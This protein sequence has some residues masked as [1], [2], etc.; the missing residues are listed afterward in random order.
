M[1]CGCVN[2][3]SL[4]LQPSAT[5]FSGTW[6]KLAVL[7]LVAKSALHASP[8]C[9]VW[10]HDIN[11]QPATWKSKPEAVWM[12]KDSVF[13]K[14]PVWAESWRM[15]G[16]ICRQTAAQFT[17]VPIS[18]QSLVASSFFPSASSYSVVHRVQIIISAD[19]PASLLKWCRF[20]NGAV[21]CNHSLPHKV[22]PWWRF[23]ELHHL[24]LGYSINT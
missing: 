16:L 4:H 18:Q 17:K 6:G 1:G 10:F 7:H 21:I 14:V 22:F 19:K 23:G 5:V 2:K 3:A 24:Q 13:T 11:T 20:L 15:N 12:S 9:A 8:R